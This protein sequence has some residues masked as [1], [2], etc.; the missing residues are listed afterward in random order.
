MWKDIDE[1]MQ[2]NKTLKA[3]A[4]HLRKILNDLEREAVHVNGMK[5]N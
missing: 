3:K 5:E 1:I 2:E 4:M